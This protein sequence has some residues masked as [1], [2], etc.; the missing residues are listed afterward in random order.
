M[1]ID[2][3]DLNVEEHTHCLSDPRPLYLNTEP[4]PTQKQFPAIAERT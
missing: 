1:Q 2:I 4:F 3:H